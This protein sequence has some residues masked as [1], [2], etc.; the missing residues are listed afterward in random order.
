[1]SAT[2]ARPRALLF[3]WD[4]TLVDSWETI[5][6]ALVVTFTAMGREPWTLQETKLRVA[7]SLR[8]SFPALFGARWEEAR[9]RYLEAFAAIHLERLRAVDGAA[10][11]LEALGTA[12]FLLGVVSNKTGRLLRQEAEHLGWTRH[13][14]R[15]VGAG[16][17]E[18]DKPHAAPVLLALEGSGI[19]CEATWYVGDTAL[20]MECARNAGCWSV[21]ID[22]RPLEEESFARFPPDLHVSDCR[23]FA[24]LVQGL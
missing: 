21:L 20:D 16:D 11:M 13:F 10:E 12:G 6:A 3:D 22:G 9:Q 5:H 14:R 8:D 2:P 15:L 7:R 24:R 23:A 18:L 4:N 1:M 17:A 19:G